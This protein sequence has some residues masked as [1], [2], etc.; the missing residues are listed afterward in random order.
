M[1]GCTLGSSC[2]L[3]K[4]IQ[5]FSLL[6]LLVWSCVSFQLSHTPSLHPFIQLL[7]G[8]WND[9][10]WVEFMKRE[11]LSSFPPLHNNNNSKSLAHSFPLLVL[12]FDTTQDTTNFSPHPITI[13]ERRE[14]SR[15]DGRRR[16]RMPMPMPGQMNPELWCSCQAMQYWSFNNFHW[17]GG[18]VVTGKHKLWLAF[19]LLHFNSPSSC[20][21][22]RLVSRL[23]EFQRKEEECRVDFESTL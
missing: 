5:L 18:M 9:M 2:E 11:V 10:M 12:A 7:E 15:R 1:N 20:Y 13:F 22:I 3:N 17:V 14:W 4:L 21:T 8:N 16:E 23:S 19:F 6:L